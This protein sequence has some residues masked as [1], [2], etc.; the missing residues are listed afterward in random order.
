MRQLYAVFT[1]AVILLVSHVPVLAQS[2]Q[3]SSTSVP[4]LINVTGV[5]RPADGQPVNTVESV[6]LSI[7]AEQAGGTPLWQETQTVTVDERG[8]Y[9]LLLGA[10][11]TGGI[12][13]EVFGS[14]EAHWLGT[15]FERPGEGDGARVRLTSVPYALR[16][17]NADT[18]GGRPASDYVVAPGATGS[19][20]ANSE[21]N[22]TAPAGE[23]PG[24]A[25]LLAK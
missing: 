25:N 16:A 7:Y 6:T 1:G 13:L 17:A 3:S 11:H 8:R 10:T 15:R 18:L 9:S 4:R 23:L 14:T 22:V 5:F 20:D 12:P 21:S 24:T 2:A 19:R